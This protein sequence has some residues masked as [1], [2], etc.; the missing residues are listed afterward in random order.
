MSRIFFLKFKKKNSLVF[1][2]LYTLLSL[3]FNK[4]VREDLCQQREKQLAQWQDHTLLYL[5]LA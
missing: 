3:Q 1:Y 2:L 4:E 5:I